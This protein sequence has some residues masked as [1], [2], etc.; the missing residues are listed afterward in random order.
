MQRTPVHPHVGL[1][2][3]PQVTHVGPQVGPQV[4]R[5]VTQVCPQVTH[6]GPQVSPQVTPHVS[7]Y[8]VT[9]V[10]V[11]IVPVSWQPKP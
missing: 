10:N 7:P 5:H 2:V 1:Q 11:T 9:Q 4:G 3:R 6:V 8:S